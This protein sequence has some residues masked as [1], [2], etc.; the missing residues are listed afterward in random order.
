[1]EY[2]HSSTGKKIPGFYAKK[3]KETKDKNIWKPET[4]IQTKPK[5]QV[6]LLSH[7]KS[8]LPN[9]KGYATYFKYIVLD[10]I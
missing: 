10:N 1:M 6:I 9:Q 4:S 2:H 8:L 3:L 5:Q 7:K